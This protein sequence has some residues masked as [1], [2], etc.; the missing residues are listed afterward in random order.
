MEDNWVNNVRTLLTILTYYYNILN[1]S[2]AG[3]ISS[4]WT[5][6]AVFSVRYG[7]TMLRSLFHCIYV[8][9]QVYNAV[10]ENTRRGTVYWL[11]P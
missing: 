2:A 7:Q 9:I 4:Y 6:L 5:L 11:P 8:P 3:V 10:S 1:Q